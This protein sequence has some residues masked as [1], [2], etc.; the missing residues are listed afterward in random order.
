M[1][2]AL[3]AQSAQPEDAAS[4]QNAADTATAATAAGTPAAATAADTIATLRSQIDA[5][6]EAIISLV[7]ERVQVSKLIQTTRI[8]DGGT[9]VELGRERQIL[10]AY[11]NRLGRDGTH[12]ADA[13]LQYCRGQR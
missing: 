12:L 13:V 4:G 7:A 10:E 3:S 11:R 9:R 2:S 8:N 6:D 5:I 1:T